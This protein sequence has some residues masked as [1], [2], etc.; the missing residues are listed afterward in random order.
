MAGFFSKPFNP[1]YMTS[2][3]TTLYPVVWFP[4]KAYYEKN[5]EQSFR[6]LA[7]ERVHLVDRKER[8]FWQQ[9]SYALPQ[10]A[11]APL[12]LIG[13]V[14]AI[15]LG[16]W[17]LIAFALGL[18]CVA[19]WPSP[20]RTYWEQRG[21][22]MSIAVVYWMTG[23]FPEA[24]RIGIKRQFLDWAY[25]RMSWSEKAIDQWLAETQKGIAEGTLREQ[26]PVFEDVYRFLHDRGLTRV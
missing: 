23:E 12:L 13:V 6:I 26:E 24:Q 2:F 7:H 5:P 18:A 10:V 14:L 4:D 1:K 20:W 3:T 22:A 21:Y 11:A 16:W 25:F 15:F 17:S 9:L 19:P 8:G